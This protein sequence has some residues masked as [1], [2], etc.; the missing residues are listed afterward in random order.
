[1]TEPFRVRAAQRR[2]LLSA[3]VCSYVLLTAFLV[4]RGSPE[5]KPLD[6]DPG[7]D[8]EPMTAASPGPVKRGGLALRLHENSL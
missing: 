2:R 5:S 8:R 3:G 6:P 4:Q 1:L 7:E